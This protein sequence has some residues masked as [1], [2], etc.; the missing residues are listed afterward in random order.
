MRTLTCIG[1][2]IPTMQSCK[3][4]PQ[5]IEGLLTSDFIL[6]HLMNMTV[7]TAQ[8]CHDTE[9]KSSI[10]T[11]VEQRTDGVLIIWNVY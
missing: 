2:C 6:I 11:V 4:G 9:W 7:S 5:N 1:E 8:H 3:V 10:M